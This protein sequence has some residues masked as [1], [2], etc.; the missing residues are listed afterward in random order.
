MKGKIYL[1]PNTIGNNDT[2]ISIPQYVTTIINT[3]D[4]YIVEDER[5][6]RR[7]LKRAGVIKP[8]DE[9]TFFL[10]NKHTNDK[11]IPS[12]L[13]PAEK[14][15]NIGIVSEAGCPAV[16]DPGAQIA[17]MAHQRKLQVVPLVGPSSILLAL[18]ASGLGGQNFAFVGYLP[19]KKLERVKHIRKLEQRTITEKQTQIF[20]EAPYRNNHMMNDILAN[21]HPETML[22]IAAD[23]TTEK[24]F[25]QTKRI[26]D[27]KKNIPELHKRP[28]VFLLRKM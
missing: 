17:A 2:T 27:W 16:A 24:E 18:M 5:T 20:M 9:L 1:I 10:L 12:F 3:I 15:K 14:G 13:A 4:T 11:I 21:C 28:T 23:I 26:I 22:C 25:I 19:V 8:I 7:F 6:V